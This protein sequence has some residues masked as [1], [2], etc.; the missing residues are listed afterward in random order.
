[1]LIFI[2]LPENNAPF[3]LAL[4]LKVYLS[5]MSLRE[6]SGKGGTILLLSFPN[7]RNM[8]VC[9]TMKGFGYKI[10]LIPSVGRFYPSGFFL[11]GGFLSLSEVTFK[12]FSEL[13][14]YSNGPIV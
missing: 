10:Y 2:F 14:G 1:M 4:R 8:S 7:D 11:G 9:F 6:Q 13:V 5:V 3:R 12:L